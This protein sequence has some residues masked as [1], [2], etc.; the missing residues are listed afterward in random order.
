MSELAEIVNQ[1]KTVESNIKLYENKI[2]ELKQ[3]KE[4]CNNK[5][6]QQ[7]IN[8]DVML[9][10]DKV[11]L[12][13]DEELCLMKKHSQGKLKSSLLYVTHSYRILGLTLIVKR[14]YLILFNMYV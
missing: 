14:I 1:L 6:K 10:R 12:F 13:R 4:K 9:L 3:E 7:Q 2:E 8:I 11:K 5:D